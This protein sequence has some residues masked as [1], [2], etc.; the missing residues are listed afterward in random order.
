MAETEQTTGGKDWVTIKVPKR[1]R[2]EAAKDPRTYE[3]LLQAGLGE[4]PRDGV[5]YDLLAEAV[6]QEFIERGWV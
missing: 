4:E 3:Q 5:D 6:A 1:T 2:D